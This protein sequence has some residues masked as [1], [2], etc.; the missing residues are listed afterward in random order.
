[1]IIDVIC[2]TLFG[3]GVF[4]GLRAIRIIMMIE[5]DEPFPKSYDRQIKYGK[6]DKSRTKLLY[7]YSLI[8]GLSFFVTLYLVLT[9][10]MHML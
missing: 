9:Y 8:V 4:Y 3:V 5:N 1:M 10:R 7:K 6:D 2:T